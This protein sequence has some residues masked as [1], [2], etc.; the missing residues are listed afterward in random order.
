MTKG[1]MQEQTQTEPICKT[2]SKEDDMFANPSS[3]WLKLYGKGQ[4]HREY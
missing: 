4:A 3:Y 1:A 2:W